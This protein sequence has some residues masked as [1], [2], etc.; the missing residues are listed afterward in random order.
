[1]STP[2]TQALLLGMKRLR[3][4][5][6]L[7]FDAALYLGLEGLLYLLVHTSLFKHAW[8]LTLP[9]HLLGSFLLFPLWCGMLRKA[10]KEDEERALLF[11]CYHWPVW[12]AILP[13][14]RRTALPER[15]LY[16]ILLLFQILMFQSGHPAL[17]YFPLTLLIVLCMLWLEWKQ[18][19]L[20]ERRLTQLDGK[21]L[22]PL[23]PK[24]VAR[25][26]RKRLPRWGSFLLWF[27]L[28]AALLGAVGSL[29]LLVLL[30]AT[31][32][33]SSWIFDGLLWIGGTVVLSFYL[34]GGLMLAALPEK[35]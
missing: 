1:M 2:G 26:A 16:A 9:V 3:A 11:S 28:G 5:P 24:E 33:F 23:N 14:W 35:E 22:M 6:V 30:L 29:V 27:L 20:L 32:G 17:W 10:L 18:F 12:R 15:I 25:S 4:R 21:V 7:V 19:C 31:G 8:L 13:V 34:T